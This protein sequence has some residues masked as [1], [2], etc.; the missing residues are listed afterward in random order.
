[1]FR[2]QI[3]YILLLAF[4]IMRFPAATLAE[5]V[6]IRGDFCYQYGDSE[7]LIAA[8]EIAYA[9]ALRKAIETYKT[10]VASTSVVDDFQLKKDL[11][12]TI[13][14][15]Y[16]D[17]VQIVRQDIV[18]RMVCTELVGYVDSEDLKDILAK[19]IKITSEQRKREFNGIISNLYLKILNYKIDTDSGGNKLLRLFYQIKHSPPP[20][21]TRMAVFCFDHQGNP[22]TTS[23][24]DIVASSSFQGAFGEQT[25]IIPSRAVSINISF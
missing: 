10:F 20:G 23:F 16:V 22:I 3:G 1:M 4:A 13:V 9:M 5:Q 2:R 7:S 17:N 12:E 21:G 24:C 11:I 14:S 18:G 8:K 19:K 15:G 6:E 25:C